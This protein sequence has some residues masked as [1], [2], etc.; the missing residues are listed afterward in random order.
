MFCCKECRWKHEQTQHGLKY[1]CP[2]CRGLE[3]LC[4]PKEL[5]EQF[6]KHLEEEHLPLYCSKCNKTLNTMDDMIN[7]DKCTS[8]SELV[9]NQDL[10]ADEETFK[11][12]FVEIFD[13]T[14]NEEDFEALVSVNKSNNTAVITPII[15]KK[16]LVDY[17]SSG[18][19]DETREE[20]KTPKT[21]SV[22]LA[23]KTPNR[24]QRSATPHVKKL[25]TLMKQKVVEED[26]ETVDGGKEEDC[27]NVDKT[28]PSRNAENCKC[29]KNYFVTLLRGLR[30]IYYYVFLRE[31]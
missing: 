31:L 9:E 12:N 19:E 13:K 25:L 5:T 30:C 23:P 16:N 2:V 11:E 1:D 21:P 27:L 17:D 15:R 14:S 18:T 24:R 6:L 8:M 29:N 22:K 3:Y 4:K 26:D 28:T 20:V 7:I 10:K